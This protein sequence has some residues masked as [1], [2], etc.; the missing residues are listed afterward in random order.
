M[1]ALLSVEDKT[2]IVDFARDL[3]DLGWEIISTGKTAALIASHDIPVTDIS[4]VTGFAEMLDGRVKTLHPAV[5]GAILA[6]RDSPDHMAQIAAQGIAPIDL[7]ASNLY[8]FAGTVAQPDVTLAGAVE[9]IDIGGVTLLRAAAK[10]CDAVTV[11]MRPEDYPVVIEELRAH[12]QTLAATRRKL[13]AQAFAHTAAYDGQ[14]A[15]YLAG[16]DGDVFPTEL[17]LPLGRIES[18]RYGENPHQQAAFYRWRAP[19]ALAGQ[20]AT[21]ADAEALHGKQLGYNNLM[22]LDAALAIVADFAEPAA[23]VVKHAGPCGIA[24]SSTLVEAFRAARDCDPVSAF[25]GIVGLNRPVDMAMAETIRESHFDAI[26]APDYDEDALAL[27]EHKRKNLILVATHRPIGPLTGEDTFAD[28]E[29][30]RV[31]GGVLL[32]TPNHLPDSAIKRDVVTDRAPTDEEW[33]GLLFAW[34][35]VKHVKSNAIVLARDN[36]T[37]GIGGGQ[38]NRVDSVRIAI[39]RAGDR[40][41]RSVLASDAYFPF[42]DNIEVAAAAGITAIIQ[43]GGSIRDPEVI[44]AA[45]AHG[46]AM[47][48]TGYRNFRH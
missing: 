20:R 34:K 39:T 35:A 15:L 27:L 41:Q 21:I 3:V 28:M 40:V 33:Q 30:R 16:L 29:V 45:N 47:V 44:Q 17:A 32:Q 2:G 9:R 24:R 36:A 5:H 8:D 11:I 26:I 14:I 12:G 48:F 38:P 10:N 23:A 22:D 18:L 31:S 7:V 6:R 43:P 42:A 46:L 25:G 37:V 1:R 13:A 4:S 19:D